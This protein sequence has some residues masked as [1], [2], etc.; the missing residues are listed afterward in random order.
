VSIDLDGACCNEEAARLLPW[1][2]AG[3]L[4]AAD[5]ERVSNH[6]QYCAICRNDVEQESAVRALLKADARVEYAPQAG[7]AKTLSRIDELGRDAP[8]AAPTRMPVNPAR[9]RMGAM[10]WLTAAVL[11]QAVAL[12][13]L[14]GSLRHPASP[15]AA[16]PRYVTLS[17]DPQSAAGAH[18]R[19][20]FAPSMTLGDLKAL[21][22]ANRLMVI[23]GPSDAGA[24]T[25]ASTDPR[26]TAAQLGTA[27]LGLRGDSRV[28]FAE[29]AVNDAA[30]AQ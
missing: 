8:A 22:G 2:V 25:L 1:Y 7:L 13:W 29:P 18:I 26:S 16:A 10:R 19:A 27:V 20:V 5:V 9:R 14:G 30:P 17:A 3:R 6:L 28:L 15:G 11:V 12:A 23:S 24:Y 21:L 4:S